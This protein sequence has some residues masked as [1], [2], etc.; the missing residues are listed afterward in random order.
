MAEDAERAGAPAVAFAHAV[1]E[2]VA[3]KIEVLPFHRVVASAH[4]AQCQGSDSTRRTA[5]VNADSSA[6]EIT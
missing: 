3:R 5:S 4:G 2:Y 1:H 6:G